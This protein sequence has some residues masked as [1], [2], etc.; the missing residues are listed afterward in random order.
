[1]LF[2][3]HAI[4]IKEN[5]YL[6]MLG[7]A[8][9]ISPRIPSGKLWVGV[10]G[11]PLV[12]ARLFGVGIQFAQVDPKLAQVESKFGSNLPKFI[13]PSWP[14]LMPS[15]PKLIPSWPK[16]AQVHPNQQQ[17]LQSNNSTQLRL[18]LN[19]TQTHL[20]SGLTE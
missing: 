10:Q 11:S 9:S 19:S 18:R 15:W 6:V 5:Q 8:Y 1:M 4:K 20:S 13:H 16:F 12:P 3:P 7:D 2:S 17:Q 14:K